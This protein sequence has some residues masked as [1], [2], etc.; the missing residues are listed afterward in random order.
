MVDYK[1]FIVLRELSAELLLEVVRE[2][3]LRISAQ[4]ESANAADQRAMT[5]AGMLTAIDT[6]AIGGTV[7]LGVTEQHWI[8]ICVGTA[9]VSV[10]LIATFMAVS[11]ARPSEFA[12]PGNETKNW[13][14][15]EWEG[16]GEEDLDMAQA[17]IEQAKALQSAIEKNKQ[18]AKDTTDQL[19]LSIDL[20]FWAVLSSAVLFGL[21][22]GWIAIAT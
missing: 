9:F 2:G 12:F 20:T 18:W 1:N 15:K 17:R 21:S 5:W 10:M 22:L 14:P 7:T 16:Y 3:E 13:F 8:L 6:A 11:A 19:R 4:L